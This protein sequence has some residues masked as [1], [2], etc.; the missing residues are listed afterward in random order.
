M[1]VSIRS[2]TPSPHLESERLKSGETRDSGE[3]F[4]PINERL[5]QLRRCALEAL[6]VVFETQQ[7]TERCGGRVGR[8]GESVNNTPDREPV[9]GEEHGLVRCVC[10]VADRLTYLSCR[11][12]MAFGEFGVAVRFVIGTKCCE[13]VG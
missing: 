2:T 7:F 11:F 3:L 1:S 12:G 9:A 8:F 10:D 13:L 6:A 5:P 4:S